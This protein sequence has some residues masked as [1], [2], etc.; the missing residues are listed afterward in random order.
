MRIKFP[1]L[2]TASSKGR[3]IE[4][5]AD[6]MRVGKTTAV[7]V[8]AAGLR[9]RG[10]MVEESYEDWQHN[11]YL[12]D[13]YSDPATA[14]LESQKWFITRKWEQVKTGAKEGWFVQDVCPE[15]DFCYAATNMQLGRMSPEH[16]LKYEQY[17]H[18][19]DWSQAPAPDLLVYLTVSDEVLIQR[20]MDSRREFETVDPAYFLMMKKV[21]Q[22][23]LKEAKDVMSILVVETDTLNFATD[24]AA[25]DILLSRVL[26]RVD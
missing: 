26:E 9:S 5:A 12:K 14:F 10:E 8:L 19:L 25:K 16:F 7:Q 23:W 13:S 11:P 4:V 1:Q 3:R 22:A 20:A 24:Q 15:M 2:R 17:Y 6:S 21:N 18:S